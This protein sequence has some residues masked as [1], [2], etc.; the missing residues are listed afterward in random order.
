MYKRQLTSDGFL[1]HAIVNGRQ[2]TP[3]P[4]FAGTLSPTDMD[5]VTAFLRSR[6][7]GWKADTREPVSYTHL[8]VYKRQ[9]FDSTWS[10]S[11]VDGDIR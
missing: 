8:D 11:S 4:A 9:V 1:R 5:N 3:M 7:T 10:C 2:G 6:S